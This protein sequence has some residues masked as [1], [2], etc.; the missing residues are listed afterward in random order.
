MWSYRDV[1]REAVNVILPGPSPPRN[2]RQDREY[3]VSVLREPDPRLRVRTFF[4]ALRPHQWV[5]N[6]LLFV[7]LLLAHQ[8]DDAG[9][10]L[11]AAIGFVVFSLCASSA[12]LINDVVDREADRRHPT[13]RYRPFAAGDLPPAVAETLQRA[14]LFGGP[15]VAAAEPARVVLNVTI[16]APAR[17]VGN[18]VGS[19]SAPRGGWILPTS[20][21]GGGRVRM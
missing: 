6:A 20:A 2:P 8:L 4:R 12:Y 5:K 17:V 13:K 10:W 3:E 14:G 7:P 16:V 21:R 15:A 1:R 18:E 11:A 9:A 19:I